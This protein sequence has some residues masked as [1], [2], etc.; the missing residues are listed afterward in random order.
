MDKIN[1]HCTILF[2][3]KAGLLKG[4]PGLDMFRQQIKQVELDAAVW[5]T[6]NAQHMRQLIKHLKTAG[7]KKIAVAGG[8]GTVAAA[9]QELAYT[10]TTFGIIPLGTYNNFA[11]ALRLP[12]DTISAL[13]VLKG[14]TIRSVSLGKANGEYFTEAAGVGL[15]ADALA[16][17]GIG[18][19]KNFL[20]GTWAALRILFSLPSH[21]IRLTIDGVPYVDRAVMCTAANSYR[22]GAAFPVAPEARL[23]DDVLDVV[24]IGNLTYREL[25][26]YYRALRHQLHPALPKVTT[27]KAKEII[28]DAPAKLAVHADD[29]IVGRTPIKV[30]IAPR[31]ISILVDR[32]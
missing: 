4:G 16:L 24:V 14:N 13:R 8:D 30:E 26:P 29:H 17:Y 19:N 15:F 1:K 2:N 10:K 27:L 28:I 7:V 25:I 3:A 5:P 12:Q 9:V 23:T 32:L 6:E 18:Q 11:T 21:R 20:V 22:L 31:A